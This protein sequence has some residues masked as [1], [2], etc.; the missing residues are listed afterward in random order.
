MTTRTLLLTLAAC[1]LSSCLLPDR[2]A[3]PRLFT[4]V[5]VAGS[6]HGVVAGPAVRIRPVR[7]P[8]HLREAIAW[9]RDDTEFGTYEQRRWTELPASYVEREF[10]DALATAGVAVVGSDEAPAL[11]VDLLHFEEALA[12]AHEAVVELDVELASATRILLRRRFAS[13]Q[14]LSADDPSELARGIGV[15]LDRVAAD[16]ARAIRDAAGVAAPAHRKR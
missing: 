7:S 14:P 15:A 6:P 16:A 11:T 5:T 2:P 10:D 4:P 12:P 3:P 1:A 13:R 8:L 9:Q